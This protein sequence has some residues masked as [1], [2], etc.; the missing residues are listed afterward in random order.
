[1]LTG[2][3]G[4]QVR[5]YVGLLGDS[6]ACLTAVIIAGA[7]AWR[8]PRGTLRTAWACLSVAIALY[9]VGTMIGVVSWLHERDP[10]P[11]PADYFFLT[12]YPFLM[13]AVGFM[14]RHAAVRVRWTQFLLDAVIMVAGFGAFFWF[15]IIRPAES[16]AELD[17]LKSTLSQ[18]YIAL[19]CILV[20]SLG[21]LLLAGAANQS[22]RSVPLLHA[23]AR[24]HGPRRLGC[25]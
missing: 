7:T 8:L 3:G 23:Q 15:L 6:P 18:V 2:L 22:G 19:N 25:H 9:F 20:L 16:S 17:V 21:V 13:L 10:F 1:M 11:G 24:Y 4:P 12:F 14:I 5:Q